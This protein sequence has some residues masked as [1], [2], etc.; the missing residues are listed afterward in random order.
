MLR[1]F[2]R[3]GLFGFLCWAIAGRVSAEPIQVTAGSAFMYWDG[4]GS[5]ATLLGSGLNVVTDTYGGGLIGFNAGTP[6]LDG[7]IVFGTLGAMQHP[8]QVTVGGVD[9]VAYLDG[10]LSFDTDPFVAPPP[11]SS[12]PSSATFSTPFT[13]NGHLLGSSG[14]QGSGSVL[15]DVQLTGNGTASTVARPVVS[16]GYLVNSGV[17][18]ELGAA[19]PE[20]A[21]LLL[22]ASGLVGVLLRNRTSR[23]G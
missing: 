21:T 3:V 23:V 22:M 8:W 2:R 1:V 12:T 13:L 4:T 6:Q 14:P 15:F 19:T 5:F 18:Y 11:T 17:T 9:Y 7:S 20:P 10:F 16:S